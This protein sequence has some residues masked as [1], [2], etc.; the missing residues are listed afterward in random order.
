MKLTIST[1]FLCALF[2]SYYSQ[3]QQ[4]PYW[5]E[6]QLLKQQDK[7]QPPPHHAVL[8][9]GSSSFT[10]WKDV[11]SYFPNSRIINRGF[12]GSTLVDVIRYA[13]DVIYPYHPKQVVIYCGEN[14]L[15]YVD[16]VTAP[17][18]LARFK[19]LFAMV[20]HHLPHANIVFVSIKPSPS[21]QAIRNKVEA[22]NALIKQFL[23][24]N[25]NTAFVNVYSPML[26]AAGNPRP[27]LFLADSLHMQP[28][29]YAIWKKA[30]EPYLLK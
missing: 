7:L 9:V 10:K 22:A 16:T 1:F 18:V 28:A 19:T 14:D 29:G 25:A 8:F 21:R 13:G 11:Q 26:N 24:T 15:A 12:G 6:I 5:K 27:E 3:A 2:I 4:P 17:T 20:R 23:A 30:I